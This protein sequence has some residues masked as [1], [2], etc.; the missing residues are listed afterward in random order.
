MKHVAGWTFIGWFAGLQLLAAADPAF[1]PLLFKAVRDG[2]VKAIGNWIEKDA[3]LNARD[4]RGNTPLHLAALDLDVDTVARLIKAGANLNVANKWGDTPLIYSASSLEKVQLLVQHGADINARATSG[5]T[6]LSAA[7]TFHDSYRVIHWLLDHGAIPDPK[8]SLE[9]RSA[10][11]GGDVETVKLLLTSGALNKSNSLDPFDSPVVLAAV[12]GYQPI[13][14]LLAKNTGAAD[15]SEGSLNGAFHWAGFGQKSSLARSLLLNGANLQA[16]FSATDHLGPPQIDG[17]LPLH[18]AVY[19]EQDA[20]DLVRLSL[21]KGADPN[22][23]NDAGETALDWV[24]KRGHRQTIAALIAAGGK[25]GN[26]WAKT[27]PIPNRAVPSSGPTRVDFVRES[28]EQALAL[29]ERSSDAFIASGLAQTQNCVSCHHQSLTSVAANWANARGIRP[30]MASLRRNRDAT[31]RMLEPRIAKCYEGILPAPNPGIENGYMLMQLDALGHPADA[32]TDA[33]VWQLAAS[34]KPDGSWPWTAT[35][36]PLEHGQI[37]ATALA[38][39]SLWTYPL[40]S[41][42]KELEERIERAKSWLESATAESPTELAFQLL[43]LSWAG[44]KPLSITSVSDAILAAQK[45]DGG[46]A[47]LAN[48]ES[49]AWMTGLNLVALHKAGDV[50]A[51]DPAYRR[52]IDF[53]L[54]TQFDDGSWWVRSR[55]IPAQPHFDS[56]FPH[57]KDQFISAAGTGWATLALLLTLDTTPQASSLTVQLAA[58]PDTPDGY[59][60]AVDKHPKTKSSTTA[61]SFKKDILPI[62]AR[63]CTDCHGG[64]NPRGS[65]SS[66]TL[67]GLMKGGQSGNPSLI[68]GHANISPLIRFTRDEVEDLEMPPLTERPEYAPLTRDEIQKLSLWIGQGVPE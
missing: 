4:D 43:G 7:G 50:E 2:D 24:N 54:R 39:K 33:L 22:A 48:L 12:F 35:R 53:L 66:E 40:P 67:A 36:P 17:T 14:E 9:I 42:Q 63:S 61:L 37:K 3:D 8:E 16:P 20:A 68:A 51:D 58:L 46:W 6:V 28:V 31:L 13:V 19:N 10:V 34:Q 49:D 38:V 23:V 15:G 65:F 18:W 5:A 59:A 29:M 25:P 1:T 11:L 55:T 47:S 45:S 30:D 62:L 27:K 21:Q 52:G 56:H 44:A 32:V 60:V 64:E 26:R 41:R 57:G